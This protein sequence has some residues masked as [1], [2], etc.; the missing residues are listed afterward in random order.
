[1]GQK[2]YTR[3]ENIVTRKPALLFCCPSR[4][5]QENMKHI[6][7]EKM[8]G[9]PALTRRTFN[10]QLTRCASTSVI[11]APDVPAPTAKLPKALDNTA[12][13]IFFFFFP[14]PVRETSLELLATEPLP[15]SCKGMS[16]NGRFFCPTLKSALTAGRL[17]RC[18]PR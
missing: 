9:L 12:G 10:V 1:V 8:V 14:L 3:F 5:G 13:A 6:V 4:K 17:C 16:R 15:C 2:D 18:A 7:A 11:S